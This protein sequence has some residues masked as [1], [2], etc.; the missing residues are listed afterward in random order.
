MK[1]RKGFVQ[2][3]ETLMLAMLC[4]WANADGAAVIMLM[5]SVG[6]LFGKSINL[7]RKNNERVN[8]IHKRE[9]WTVENSRN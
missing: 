6:L 2:G 5:V 8:D 4:H 1:L 9:V 3:I 7:R